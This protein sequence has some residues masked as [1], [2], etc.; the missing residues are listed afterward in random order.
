MV[1]YGKAKRR[2]RKPPGKEKDMTTYELIEQLIEQR[3]AELDTVVK[4]I[5][6]AYQYNK[7]DGY[8]YEELVNK[9]TDKCSR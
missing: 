9:A 7:I 8:E 4:V 2:G 5:F 6:D 1:G 3:F